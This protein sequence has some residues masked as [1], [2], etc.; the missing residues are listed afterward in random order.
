MP[1]ARRAARRA[2]RDIWYELWGNLTMNP[3]SALTGATTEQIVA[4]PLVLRLCTDA[5][6]E[7][8]RPGELLDCPIEQTPEQRHRITGGLGAFKTSMLQ[9]VLAGRPLELDAL[10]GAVHERGAR[11]G[12]PTPNIDALFGLARLMARVRGLYPWPGQRDAH[13]A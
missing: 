6:R 8:H 11:H 7:A 13:A 9:D 10:V 3:V 12:L 5:M 2:I 1:A 4:D